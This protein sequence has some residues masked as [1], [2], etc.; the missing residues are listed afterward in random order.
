MS[1]TARHDPPEEASFSIDSKGVVLAATAAA[2][3]IFSASTLPGRSLSNLVDASSRPSEWR[4]DDGTHFQAECFAISVGLPPL[5]IRLQLPSDAEAGR[6]IRRRDSIISITADL[7]RA[8]YSEL[9]REIVD[10][11]GRLGH[12]IEADRVYVF[13]MIDDRTMR[14]THE[15]SRA[16]VAP[17]IDQLQTVSREDFA[18]LEK[19]LR[20]DGHYVLHSLDQLPSG[21]HQARSLLRDG[22]VRSLMVIGMFDGDELAGFFG[23][24]IVSRETH[25]SKRTIERF[26]LI[27]EIFIQSILRARSQRELEQTEARLRAVVD[28]ISDVIAIV[29]GAG[30]NIYLSPSSS[31]I[32]GYSPAEMEGRS[33]FE[34]VHPE[35]CAEVQGLFRESLE[36][37][38]R[39]ASATYR[40]RHADGDWLTVETVG[41]NPSSWEQTGG[42]VLVS[43]DITNRRMAERQMERSARVTSLGHLASSV[44]HE[45]NNILMGMQPFVDIA[46]RT[47]DLEEAKASVE[48]IGEALDHGKSISVG[49][50]QLTR[51]LTVAVETFDL[52]RWMLDTEEELR[53]VVPR[54]TRWTL[55]VPDQPIA[56]TGDPVA[57]HQ[58]VMNL[59]LSASER[60]GELDGRSIEIDL[61]RAGRSEQA[62]NREG[63]DPVEHVVLSVTDDGPGM[64]PGMTERMF[65]PMF[66]TRQ[67]SGA[68]LGLAV[69]YQLARAQGGEATVESSS[70]GTTF[71]VFLR[72][73]RSQA[74]QRRIEDQPRGPGDSGTILLVEDNEIVASGLVAV[75]EFDG[76]KVGVAGTGA[77]ALEMI[78]TERPSI[79]I[80]DIGLPDMSGIDVYERIVPLYPDLPVIFSSGH[81]DQQK[82]KKYLDRPN[83]AFL[84][85]PYDAETLMSLVENLTA[86]A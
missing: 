26:E 38:R 46:R 85:K 32:F 82:L 73:A 49:L 21:A 74:E 10:G 43:R 2:E 61:R 69:V 8:S 80:L 11:L 67:G 81:G 24:D 62:T 41:V 9:D 77:A 27:G 68:G 56:I 1:G 44:A 18:W 83:V 19:N 17:Q 39:E 23:F 31:R 72:S 3:T 29:D 30:N 22:G 50:L 33:A 63:G 12:L 75:L 86:H 4:R 64:D 13:L 71:R 14:N 54:G 47:D 20:R 78:E 59:V 35:D 6:S 34:H 40:Y 5:E 60:I 66:T 76:Q 28:H 16:G 52:R 51:P 7:A 25:W 58:I 79:V 84:L 45:F 57:L 42:V 36:E 65:D 48:K 37:G 70:V 53:L 55:R 15:W